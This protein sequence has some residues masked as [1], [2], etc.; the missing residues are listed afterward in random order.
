M[1][2]RGGTASAWFGCLADRCRVRLA[3]GLPCLVTRQRER[4]GRTV[5]SDWMRC[6]LTRNG[7]TREVRMAG[8]GI[9]GTVDE[10]VAVLIKTYRR[11]RL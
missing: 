11:K 6:C 10:V 4:S 7:K 1:V 5:T 9:F 8:L 3:M 2:L